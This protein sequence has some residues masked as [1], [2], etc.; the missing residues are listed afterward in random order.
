MTALRWAGIACRLIALA[1]L[2]WVVATVLPATL[3]VLRRHD[4]RIELRPRPFV[5]Q[6]GPTWT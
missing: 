2:L 5:I 6:R 3:D 4:L 1:L